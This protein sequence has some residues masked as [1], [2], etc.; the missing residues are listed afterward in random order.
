MRAA[1]TL[2]LLACILTGCGEYKQSVAYQD[3]TYQGKTDQRHWDNVRFQHDKAT[4]A[5]AI[6]AR[7]QRQNE[8]KRT[9]D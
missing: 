8:Y 1:L 9:G 5:S 4:W 7:A 3:G 2:W 6:N